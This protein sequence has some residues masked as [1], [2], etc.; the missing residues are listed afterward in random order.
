MW[1]RIH[2]DL[3]RNSF[4]EKKD[5]CWV[6][7]KIFLGIK[8][9]KVLR[10]YVYRIYEKIKLIN[11][12]LFR[13]PKVGR[14]ILTQSYLEKFSI[15]SQICKRSNKTSAWFQALAA[16]YMRSSLFWYVTQGRFVLTDVSVQP[17]VSIFKGQAFR[18]ECREHT[19]Y[20]TTWGICE[21][22]V[23]LRETINC[24]RR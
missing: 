24:P 23:V 19:R 16:M 2:S 6:L 13:L 14:K 20:S 15:G 17:I 3:S 22:R 4:S 5:E 10:Y 8:N 18:R 12:K 7:K 11:R 9:F 1:K 21:Q